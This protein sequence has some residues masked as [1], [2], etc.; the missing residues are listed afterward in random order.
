MFDKLVPYMILWALSTT[1]VLVLFFWRLVVAKHER[2]GI[3][4][5]EGEEQDLEEQQRIGKT[6]ARID[7]WGKTLTVVSVVLIVVMGSMW[8]WDLWKQSYKTTM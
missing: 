1:G 7:L 4:I 2:G 6:L 5:V 3:F 8:M